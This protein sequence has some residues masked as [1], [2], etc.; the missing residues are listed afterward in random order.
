MIKTVSI[1]S[2]YQ[3]FQLHQGILALPS[4]Q[5]SLVV[6]GIHLCHLLPKYILRDDKKLGFIAYSLFY[7]FI[8]YLWRYL[9]MVDRQFKKINNQKRNK[10]TTY[11]F[12]PKYLLPVFRFNEVIV[13]KNYG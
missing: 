9:I 5:A 13:D 11:G 7:Y 2:T 8:A 1:V 3:D 10:I 4:I 6:L 12:L